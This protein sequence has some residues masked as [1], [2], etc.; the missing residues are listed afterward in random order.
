MLLRRHLKSPTAAA[1]SG[2]RWKVRQLSSLSILQDSLHAWG[3]PSQFV[4]LAAHCADDQK[5][6]RFLMCQQL[7]EAP[8]C[9]VVVAQVGQPALPELVYLS[10]GASAC[11]FSQFKIKYLVAQIVRW[12]QRQRECA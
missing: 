10:A 2:F 8:H 3:Q 5:I 7:G 4:V 1:N 6:L 11:H 12:Q 9:Q